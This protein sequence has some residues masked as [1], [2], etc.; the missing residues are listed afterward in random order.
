M[1]RD[2]F[3]KF[4]DLFK[5]GTLTQLEPAALFSAANKFRRYSEDYFSQ[6]SPDK[7]KK[8]VIL[9]TLSCKHFANLFHFFLAE[10]KINATIHELEYLAPE[11]EILNENSDL[12][13]MD[14]DYLF[15]FKDERDIKEWPKL[16]SDL[17]IISQ[18]VNQMTETNLKLWSK[19]RSKLPRCQIFHA[20]YVMPMQRQLGGLE[21]NFIFSKQSSLQQLN[22][23]NIRQK[24]SG[25]YL[26]DME[27][28][29]SEIGRPN[30]FDEAS[31]YVSKQPFS[32]E[33]MILVARHLERL[34]S[35]DCG[36]IRKCLILDLDNTLWGGVIGD[37]GIEG[38]ILDPNHPLGQAYIDFQNY[39]K[40]LKERGVLLAVCSKNNLEIALEAIEN[41][42]HMSL[43]KSDFACIVA[44]WDSK[45]QNL[46]EISKKLNIGLDSMVFF[47]DNPIERGLIRSQLPMVQTIEVPQDPALYCRALDKSLAFEWTQL[48]SDDLIRN[49]TFVSQS[50]RDEIFQQNDNYDDYLGSLQLRGEFDEVNHK[51]ATRFTQLVNKTNQFN[52]RTRRYT[53]AEILSFVQSRNHFLFQVKLND[54]FS[55]Y[56]VISCLILNK[57]NDDEC[58]I[59]TWVMS[60]RVLKLGVEAL[61]IN[62][63]AQFLKKQSFKV[64]WGEY[65]PTP[66]NELVK[67]LLPNLGFVKNE[68]FRLAHQGLMYSLSLEDFTEKRHQIK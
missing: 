10:K 45:D 43:R 35:A 44:N 52:L 17:E 37:D 8:I 61:V 21:S 14:P 55:S 36:K 58:F 29:A 41:H 63:I 49:E 6:I 5:E 12:Y 16:F 23:E 27:Y 26:L 68:N 56:G 30:W 3:E 28:F 9:S 54:R 66:K 24:P 46:I 34:I 1:S 65:I 4:Q 13:K 32:L 38:I 48:S 31:Y 53:E 64:I 7:T 25:V 2:K 47:D 67:D 50:K 11:I 20:Q 51:S 15:I 59:E 42:E 39:A 19:V 33:G 22:L 40:S 62:K 57:I 18:F 60:C